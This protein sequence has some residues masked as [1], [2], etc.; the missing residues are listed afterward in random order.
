MYAA[1]LVR[2]MQPAVLVGVLQRRPPSPWLISWTSLGLLL[3]VVH[4]A[5]GQATQAA[6]MPVTSTGEAVG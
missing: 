1:A 6:T 5:V 2:E 4:T 3:I